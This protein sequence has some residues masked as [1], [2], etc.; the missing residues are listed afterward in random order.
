MKSALL[1]KNKLGLSMNQRKEIT[2]Q[3]ILGGLCD[4]C[5][6]IAALWI[7]CN[8]SKDLLGGVLFCSN[9]HIICE[10]LRER[11]DKINSS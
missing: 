7:M 2:V 9:T 8:A 6:A 11:F 5:N 1:G 10:D 4:R 3:E